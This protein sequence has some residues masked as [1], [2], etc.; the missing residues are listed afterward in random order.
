MLPVS[1]LIAHS[2][3]TYASTLAGYL[4]VLRPHFTIERVEIDDLDACIAR[5]P[6]ALVI[7]DRIS[8]LAQTAAAAYILY[9]PDQ[10][11]IAVIN[12]HGA[13]RT[14]ENPA[15]DDVLDAI[16]RVVAG[17]TVIA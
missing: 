17:I 4:K 12:A 10:M 2:L 15:W 7:A 9:Y 8:D 14:I 11:N 3:G 1:I 13:S 16:D 5:I 6:G